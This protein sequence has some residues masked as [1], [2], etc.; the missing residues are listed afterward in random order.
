MQ[1]KP[2]ETC[3]KKLEKISKNTRQRFPDVVKYTM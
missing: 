1:E 2:V 3:D